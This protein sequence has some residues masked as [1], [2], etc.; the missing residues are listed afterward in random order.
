MRQ[1]IR[2]PR[3]PVAAGTLIAAVLIASPFAVA[4]TGDVLR[5]GKRNGTAT[6]ETEII[7]NM[8]AQT[9]KGGFVTR[10]SNVSTGSDAG[11]GAIYGCRTPVGGTATGTAPCLRVSNLAGGSAFEFASSGGPVAGLISIGNPAVPNPGKP[12]VTNAVGVATGLNA[13]KVDGKD[14]SEL[15]GAT[16]PAGP[17]GPAGAPGPRGPS[18]LRFSQGDVFNTPVCADGL[19]TCTDLLSRTLA[20]GN[21]LVQ[22]KLTILNLFTGSVRSGR[23]GIAR[24]TT[25]LDE[26]FYVLEA[27]AFAGAP[28]SLALTAVVSGAPA[29]ATIALRCTGDGLRVLFAKLTALQVE[30]V[31]GP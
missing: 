24:G 3:H 14:A 10:Q 16:G 5:E 31:T 9:G 13:D 11:G 15:I 20:E 19:A 23:C 29:G 1:I 22:A 25:V 12:F 2:Q 7:G 18:N 17:A 4:G 8:K 21:W 26:A 27:N 30:T 6:K 28:E